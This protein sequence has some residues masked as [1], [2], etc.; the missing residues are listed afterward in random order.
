MDVTPKLLEEVEF[1]EK[2]RGY[3]PEEVDDFLERV[4]VAFGQLHERLRDAGEQ[5][6]GA[7]ARAARAEARARASADTDDVLRRTL[8]LAQRTADAA[9]KEA[10]ES[11]AAIVSAAEAQARQHQQASEE[12]AAE[13]LQRADDSAKGVEAEAAQRADVVRAEADAEA[14]AIRARS[15]DQAGRLLIE[16]KQKAERVVAEAES[17]AI[18]QAEEKLARLTDEVA[19]LERRRDALAHDANALDAHTT[20]QRERLHR[21][22]VDLR[23]VAE[24]SSVLG[25]IP[26][27]ALLS[28]TFEGAVAAHVARSAAPAETA[29]TAEAAV[30][31]PRSSTSASDV[32]SLWR[33]APEATAARGTVS[34]EPEVADPAA[35][36]SEVPQVS[37]PVQP[38]VAQPVVEPAP[39]GEPD[40]VLSGMEVTTGA[41]ATVP[42]IFRNIPDAV[43]ESPEAPTGVTTADEIVDLVAAEPAAPRTEETPVVSVSRLS[44]SPP[45]PPPP[46]ASRV[47]Q[48]AGTEAGL[49]PPPPPAPE[50]SLS[51]TKSDPFL[52]E[53]RRAVGEE[54]EDDEA[55]RFFEDRDPTDPALRFFE[56]PDDTRSRFRR[57]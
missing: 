37:E 57:R 33:V 40:I 7:N 55:I 46:P 17:A 1:R 13:L 44:V 48:A 36:M 10:E 30:E 12:R 3:D 49:V 31:T 47:A 21:A 35:E 19:V 45:P 25:E 41:T 20:V 29:E 14:E 54:P 43:G 34:A 50:P 24:E 11:A 52:E 51:T 2:F 5:I 22:L 32:G 38:D 8:V 6:E 28:D 4:A 26:M 53:L 42:S 18:R 23:R 15:Q 39:A 56:E 27:P 16:A 9:I